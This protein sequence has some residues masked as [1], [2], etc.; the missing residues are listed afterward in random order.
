MSYLIES[1]IESKEEWESKY[2]QIYNY[3][4]SNYSSIYG[5]E[6][7]NADLYAWLM[8]QR[9]NENLTEEQKNK[10]KLLQS[11]YKNYIFSKNYEKIL[12][13]IEKSSNLTELRKADPS[14]FAWYQEILAKYDALDDDKKQ[15]LDYAKSRLNYAGEHALLRKNLALLERYLQ[16]HGSL[17]NLNVENP[18][19]YFYLQNKKQ[20]IKRAKISDKKLKA[21]LLKFLKYYDEIKVIEKEKFFDTATKR[22]LE[23]LEQGETLK[24]ISNKENRLMVWYYRCKK[25]TNLSQHEKEVLDQ[26]SNYQIDRESLVKK[27]CQRKWLKTY[28]KLAKYYEEHD[29]S[30]E[31][32]YKN[33]PDL[34]SWWLKNRHTTNPERKMLMEKFQSIK[35]ENWEDMY[36][37]IKYKLEQ[38]IKLNTK[39]KAWLKYQ[40]ERKTSL[41]PQQIGKMVEII[42]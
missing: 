39:E 25:R 37:T 42:L 40:K 3:F 1:I 19:L 30:L 20:S 23:L 27:A 6:K 12:K 5:L 22:I 14:L 24:S 33:D 31:G 21:T 38:N 8:Q 29:S 17:E 41:T 10:I 15:K 34:Y 11:N 35:D 7:Y 16:E 26:I 9:K 2:N 32:L 36:A 4:I 13:Y 28:A 18:K